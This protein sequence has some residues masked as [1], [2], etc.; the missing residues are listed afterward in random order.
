MPRGTIV[1]HKVPRSTTMFGEVLQVN[2]RRHGSRCQVSTNTVLGTR[3]VRNRALQSF[4]LPVKTYSHDFTQ[5]KRTDLGSHGRV[6]YCLSGLWTL[7]PGCKG[8][9]TENA[10]LLSLDHKEPRGTTTYHEVPRG[11]TKRHKVPRDITRYH[12]VL[13]TTR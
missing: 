8:V 9:G 4:K 6:D 13:V 11:T 1:Y 5:C 7:S 2:R 10:T 3:V 12:L